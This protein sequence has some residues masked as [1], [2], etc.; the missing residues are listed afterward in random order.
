[1]SIMLGKLYD[2]LRT[3]QGVNETVAR[4]AAEEVAGYER[5]I[6]D[7]RTDVKVVQALVGVNTAVGLGVL[8]LVLQLSAAVARLTP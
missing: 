8:W 1:M 6:A 2:A 5:A 3:A 7:L 4:E